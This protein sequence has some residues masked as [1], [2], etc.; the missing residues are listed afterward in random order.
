VSF[1]AVIAV[2]NAAVAA[3]Y[4]LRVI[5]Y[6]YTRDPATDAPAPRHGALVW[7]GLAAATALTIV[8]GVFPNVFIGFAQAAAEAIS[9][10]PI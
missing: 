4:Y 6:M 9:T 1:L 2:L 7:G 5:V 3:F 8:L 10:L